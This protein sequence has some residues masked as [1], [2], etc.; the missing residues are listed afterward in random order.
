MAERLEKQGSGW[1]NE[2]NRDPRLRTPAGAGTQVIQKEQEKFMQQAWAQLGD[3]LQANQKIRQLQLAWMS[4][5]V[6]YQKER[7]AAT[8]RPVADVHAR[9]PGR[10]CSGSPTTIARQVKDSRLPRAALDP[11]FRKIA[12]P[13][14]AIMRKVVPEGTARPAAVLT[15]AERRNADCGAVATRSDRADL[16]RRRRDS[17]VPPSLPEWLRGLLRNGAADASSGSDRRRLAR[18]DGHRRDRI[19]AGRL[20]LAVT[21]RLLFGAGSV[22]GACME[23][24]VDAL[25][26]K[27]FTPAAVD[28][29]PPRP[30]FV[31]TE[32]DAAPAV[33]GADSGA[34]TA[35]KPRISASPSKTP[36]TSTSRPRRRCRFR[37]R[38]RS[39]TPS[40]KLKQALNPAL[41]IPQARAS[42]S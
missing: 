18:P 20:A 7:P 33:C 1:V 22:D 32:F 42:S 9:R 3:L 34:A 37:S 5:F 27:S 25:Q 16:A 21:W 13:R 12:R 15:P 31:L 10:G 38:C 17:I 19:A 40:R 14:G 2:L 35:S 24:D 23:R 30:N 26:E 8:G 36:S 28:R 11:A 29:I 6:T 41:A 39:K 4:T